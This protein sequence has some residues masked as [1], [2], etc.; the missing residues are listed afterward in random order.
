MNILPKGHYI[1][2]VDWAINPYS[3]GT[4]NAEIVVTFMMNCASDNNNHL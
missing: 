1:E 4:G 2:L 3:Y